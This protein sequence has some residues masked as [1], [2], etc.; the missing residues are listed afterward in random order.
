[1]VVAFTPIFLANMVFAQ[2]FAETDDS[3][4]PLAR[5]LLGAMVGGVLEYLSLITGFRHSCLSWGCCTRQRGSCWDEYRT[6]VL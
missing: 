2:R 3:T 1:M 4:T 6:E 5:T